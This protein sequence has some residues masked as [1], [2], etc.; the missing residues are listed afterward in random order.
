[1]RFF[2]A[3]VI[4]FSTYSRVPMPQVEWTD[5]NR[6]YAMCFFP[7]IG[8]LVGLAV[9]GWLALCDALGCGAFLSGRHIREMT[10]SYEKEI[11]DTAPLSLSLVRQDRAFAFA[12][13]SEDGSRC[14]EARG[15]M[16]G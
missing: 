12:V 2:R 10:V 13:S 15:L 6:R 14:F 7:L 4:A 8:A 1:M 16:E 11:R 3:L 5:E 9:W